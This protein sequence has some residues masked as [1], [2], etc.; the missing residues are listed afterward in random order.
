MSTRKSVSALGIAI[1]LASPLASYAGG[2]WETTTDESGYQVVAPRFGAAVRSI[3]APVEKALQSGD[4]SADRQY[5][6]LAEESG[7]QLR[8]MQFRIESGRLAHVDDPAGHMDRLADTRPLTDQE[9]AARE[10]S[11]GG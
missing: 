1:A 6:Y 3:P 8:P 4:V 5:V 9:R 10:R 11:G 2:F 7:W